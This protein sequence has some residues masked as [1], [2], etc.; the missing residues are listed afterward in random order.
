MRRGKKSM[1]RSE[2]K[3]KKMSKA[4]FAQGWKKQCKIKILRED[5][6]CKENCQI[7]LAALADEGIM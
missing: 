7:C 1:Q 5:R 6:K 3:G 4:P 2:R